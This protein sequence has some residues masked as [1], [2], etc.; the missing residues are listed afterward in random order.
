MTEALAALVGL[1]IASLFA[2]VAYWMGMGR[3]PWHW[4]SRTYRAYRK[5]GRGMIGALA[6]VWFV[7]R[8]WL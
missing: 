4:L 7:W 1:L 5:C 8:P 6:G 3:W 2:S